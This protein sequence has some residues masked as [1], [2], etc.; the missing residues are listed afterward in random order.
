MKLIKD[1]HNGLTL[2]KSCD[3]KGKYK[4]EEFIKLT[5]AL[6]IHLQLH[7]HETRSQTNFD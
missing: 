2:R 6:V 1:L 3:I 5:I 7:S 4:K